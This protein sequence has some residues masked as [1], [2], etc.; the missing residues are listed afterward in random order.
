[1][2]DKHID[3]ELDKH[4]DPELLEIVKGFTDNPV[5]WFYKANSEFWF[6]RPIDFLGTEDEWVLRNRLQMFKYG[7]FS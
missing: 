4:I 7:M 1:V 5:A 3:P 6:R 2:E